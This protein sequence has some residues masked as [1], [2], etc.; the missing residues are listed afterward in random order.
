MSRTLPERGAGLYFLFPIEYD[1][2]FSLKH[3]TIFSIS[4]QILND[5]VR[6]CLWDTIYTDLGTQK[7]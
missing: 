2:E 1:P 6:A 4:Q 5:L 7:S 3:F